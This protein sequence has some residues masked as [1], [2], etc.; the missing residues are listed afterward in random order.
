MIKYR[1]QRGTL[2][3]SVSLCKEFVDVADMLKYIANEAAGPDKEHC[4]S[5][6]D[7]VIGESHGEDKRIGWKSW[8]YVYTARYLDKNYTSRHESMPCIGICDFG[9]AE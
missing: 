9:E 2:E 8:R 6:E 7:I 1:P 5:P 3:E 4:F